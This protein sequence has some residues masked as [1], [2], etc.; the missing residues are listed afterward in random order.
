MAVVHGYALFDVSHPLVGTARNANYYA[1]TASLDLVIYA[2]VKPIFKIYF[3][4][5]MGFYLAR[6]NILTVSTCRDISD[7]IVTAIMPCLIFYNI[8]LYLKSSDIKFIGIVFFEGTMLFSVG[9][10]LALATHYVCKLPKQWL[11]GLISVGLFPN[12]SDLPIA[13]LQ[14]LATTGDLFST[15]DGNKGVAYVCI[16]LASQVFYQFSL[17]LYKLIRYDFRDQLDDEEAAP[18]PASP[19]ASDADTSASK[20][21]GG[22]NSARETPNEACNNDADVD[23]GDITDLLLLDSNESRVS[24]RRTVRS[25]ASASQQHNQ[26]LEKAESHHL[27]TSRAR[28]STLSPTTSHALNPQA[29]RTADLR[30]MPSQDMS[31]VIHEYSE[32]DRLRSTSEC[33]VAAV[34]SPVAA[35]PGRVRRAGR[36]V[37]GVLKNFLM[38]NSMSL[39]ISLAIAMAPPLKA[40][41][42]A[43]SFDMPNA[44]DK[45]PPLSFVVDTTSYV[46][47][48]SVPLGLL[49]LGATIA[50]LNVT[51][52]P[53]GFWKTALAITAC[54][55]VVLPV[56]GIGLVKGL[57]NAGWFGDDKLIQFVSVLEYGLPN[58]TA[59]V[60]FTAFYTDPTAPD[61]LQ[62][63][64]LA[65]CLIAQ[66][67]VLFITL[68]ILVTYT[69]KV[70]LGF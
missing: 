66:Y 67:S 10:L 58:A 32:F 70:Q 69:L 27:G 40:L 44:P 29:L 17:G 23:V 41:F 35:P 45:K 50:R 37:V 20:S 21:S 53:P 63:D 15:A 22:A 14:T 65:I 57:K 61:H 19:P 13:Y 3:I 36:H 59:L 2:A 46:G 54:R 24:A 64:C 33:G 56:F 62:M 51:S 28:A 47:A 49:V 43:S 60:Y 16:F 30:M 55:L 52:M 5:A 12:I 39:I 1:M 11:G 25:A 38:P 26:F 48:A 31:D 34:G 7:L 9:A 68:P 6:R 42:V 8:V 4:V 18:A